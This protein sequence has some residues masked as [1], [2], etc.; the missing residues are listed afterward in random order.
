MISSVSEGAS[1]LAEQQ[2]LRD[3]SLTSRGGATQGFRESY[4]SM[5][6]GAAPGSVTARERINVARQKAEPTGF[7]GGMARGATTLGRAMINQP[8]TMAEL[9]VAATQDQDIGALVKHY[10]QA[11]RKVTSRGQQTPFLSPEENARNDTVS[12]QPLSEDEKAK[13]VFNHLAAIESGAQL[14]F[15]R[16]HPILNL[17]GR[18]VGFVGP[19]AVGGGAAGLASRTLKAVIPGVTK[20]RRG[21]RAIGTFGAY[22]AAMQAQSIMAGGQDKFDFG[23]LAETSL[24]GSVA[25]RLTRNMGPR[26]AAILSQGAMSVPG[27]VHGVIDK[28]G[29]YGAGDF[30]MTLL[31]GAGQAVVAG[32]FHGLSPANAGRREAF[33]RAAEAARAE[34]PPTAPAEPAL[35]S[36]IEKLTRPEPAPLS[37]EEMAVVE[38]LH[39]EGKLPADALDLITTPPPRQMPESEPG[40]MDFPEVGRPGR[41]PA[42][43]GTPGGMSRSERFARAES[44][45][46]NRLKGREGSRPLEELAAKE[47][48]L[49]A[50]EREAKAAELATAETEAR[51]TNEGMDLIEQMAVL[52]ERNERPGAKEER[53]K[54]EETAQYETFLKRNKKTA[55]FRN[56]AGKKPK[57]GEAG[58]IRIPTLREIFLDPQAREA[59]ERGDYDATIVT[60]AAGAETIRNAIRKGSFGVLDPRAAPTDYMG[61]YRA[62]AKR[63]ILEKA[64]AVEESAY[65]YKG[66]IDKVAGNDAAKRFRVQDYVF[67]W[68]D[69]NIEPPKDFEKD[70]STEQLFE[71]ADA[72]KKFGKA[73]LDLGEMLHAHGLIPTRRWKGTG[74]GG[75]VRDD[76][77]QPY[78]SPQPELPADAQLVGGIEFFRNKGHY[79]PHIEAT[80]AEMARK[81]PRPNA[82]KRTIMAGQKGPMHDPKVRAHLGARH[83]T[84]KE[85]VQK[86]VVDPTIESTLDLMRREGGSLVDLLAL[87]RGQR[88]GRVRGVRELPG[89]AEN[90]KAIKRVQELD[91]EIKQWRQHLRKKD[92]SPQDRLDIHRE[93]V[94]AIAERESQRSWT[95]EKGWIKLEGKQWGP[96]ENDYVPKEDADQFLKSKEELHDWELLLRS[97]VSFYKGNRVG[98]SLQQ[99]LTDKVGNFLLMDQLGIPKLAYLKAQPE[100]MSAMLWKA[101]TP[102]TLTGRWL[103]ANLGEP[104]AEIREFW[105]IERSRGSAHGG[106]TDITAADTAELRKMDAKIAEALSKGQGAKLLKTAKGIDAVAQF[107]HKIPGF[108]HLVKTRRALI[109]EADVLSAWLALKRKGIRGRGKLSSEDAFDYLSPFD[110]K[111]HSN[112]VQR[113]SHFDTFFRYQ[114]TVG[115]ASMRGALGKASLYGVNVGAPLDAVIR[116]SG[117]GRLGQAALGARMGLNLATT[118]A[119]YFLLLMGAR[120]AAGKIAGVDMQ[121]FEEFLDNKYSF[122]PDPIRWLVKQAHIPTGYTP[123]GRPDY[124]DLSRVIPWLSSI[125]RWLPQSEAKGISPQGPV[126][127]NLARFGWETL[128]KNIVLGPAAQAFFNRSLTYDNTEPGFAPGKSAWP[129]L[130]LHIPD[131][132]SRTVESAAKVAN[133]VPSERSGSIVREVLSGFGITSGAVDVPPP[134]EK[135]MVRWFKDGVLSWR[136]DVA[137]GGREAYVL[138][139]DTQEGVKAQAFL[140]ILKGVPT[141]PYDAQRRMRS[142]IEHQMESAGL[143]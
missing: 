3:R 77:V 69:E 140:D 107:L 82:L 74:P 142:R 17:S 117:G 13:L 29:E 83:L 56:P 54:A 89:A 4:R 51:R 100:A 5:M 111:T 24:T 75:E 114:A 138:Q 134:F 102:E 37:G 118:P 143:K 50:P 1:E 119:R 21:I 40:V 65:E 93:I 42:G 26:S 108:S 141:G 38:R 62:D 127:H 126:M 48:E 135:Q 106:A 86:K 116:K 105:E 22:D 36:I 90:E 9:R 58:G 130:R 72:L 15:A 57:R 98:A 115:R 81:L 71:A 96:F 133:E 137:S 6:L 122:L 19:N 18:V 32:L 99:F 14:Q 129:F 59:R 30:G 136:E 33:K 123:L 110:Y 43:I 68:V 25:G 80:V 31:E 78:M 8:P 35:D 39:S 88:E 28:G 125:R 124:I 34:A 91:S 97:L 104:S 12:Y 73:N 46:R 120:A 79:L 44:E 61:R 95:G 121:Q 139:P 92:L 132:V 101:F 76:Y 55:G 128:N 64:T 103:R 53:A 66:L 23:R 10:D 52:T 63:Q 113:F 87:E 11:A 85:Y 27:V 47:Y 49:A 112:L 67:K 2:G 16:D 94:A 84:L 60:A 20:L 41:P 7:V 109:D 45:R 131:V 70:I